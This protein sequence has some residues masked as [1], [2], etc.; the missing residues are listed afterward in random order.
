MLY[1]RTLSF[2]HLI[3]NSLH[4]L[5]PNYGR[6]NQCENRTFPGEI[7]STSHLVAIYLVQ[8]SR[9][10]VIGCV[11]THSPVWARQGGGGRSWLP[12]ADL[13]HQVSLTASLTLGQTMPEKGCRGA[14]PGGLRGDWDQRMY[15]S[16]LSGTAW[17]QGVWGKQ[18]KKAL[19]L[20]SW[21]PAAL[22]TGS[23]PQEEP[24]PVTR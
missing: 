6:D 8:S 17:E 19:C 11:E 13:A 14:Q 15:S 4:L 20:H 24:S 18:M 7:Y 22:A 5:I 23:G 12:F 3:C 9:L 10:Q 2:I 1:S 21:T 16:H